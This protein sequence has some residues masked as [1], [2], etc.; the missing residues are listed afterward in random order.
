MGQLI[1]KPYSF[2]ALLD[3]VFRIYRRNFSLLFWITAVFFG[4]PFFAQELINIHFVGAEAFLGNLPDYLKAFSGE[5]G[6]VDVEEINKLQSLAFYTLPVSIMFLIAVPLSQGPLISAV[7]R[8]AL[9]QGSGFR[10]AFRIGR[11]KYLYLFIS[12]ILVNLLFAV[13]FSFLVIPVVLT[14]GFAN[15][16]IGLACLLFI[17]IAVPVF[18]AFV[19]IL[20]IFSLFAQAVVIEGYGPIEALIRSVRLI[21]GNWWRALG[22]YISIQIINSLI[23]EFSKFAFSGLNGLILAI[24]PDYEILAHAAFATGL[25]VV[26]VFTTPVLIL[27][28]TIYFYDLKVRREA[29]DIE[30]MVSQF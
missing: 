25:T 4:L 7:H 23:Y 10:D 3:A 29:Y 24:N 14:V 16:A 26:Q 9:G 8:N 22:I 13:V 12:F 18:A 6:G 1:L 20:V 19:Y 2:I 5:G 21:H 27:G 30:M 15:M 17:I 11:G 28:Q